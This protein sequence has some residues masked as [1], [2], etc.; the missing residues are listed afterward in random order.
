VRTKSNQISVIA[1]QFRAGTLLGKACLASM[2]LLA[3]TVSGHA[4]AERALYRYTDDDGIKVI[5]HYIPP[6]Y[7]QKGYEILN[8]IGQVTK[9]VPA[10]PTESEMEAAL[11]Q[12]KIREDFSRL[13]KR[14]SSVEDIE[15]ARGRRLKNIESNIA[16]IQSN[17]SSLK[18][19]IQ[20]LMRQAAKKERS[21]KKVSE[22]ILQQLDNKH[23]EL[24]VT[25][26]ILKLREE[27][28]KKESAKFDVAVDVFT[29]GSVLLEKDLQGY[30]HTNNN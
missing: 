15:S 20:D 17:V 13:R 2:L 16:I 5:N 22:A 19:S 18:N 4:S 12:Q 3:L 14:Y 29:K 6:S 10:A 11:A 1:S 23:Q 7:A 9:V 30:T 27:E 28:Q 25:G 21:G 8:S 26:G 24:S